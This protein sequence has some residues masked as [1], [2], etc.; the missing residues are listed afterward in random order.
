MGLEGIWLGCMSGVCLRIVSAWRM[1]AAWKDYTANLEQVPF[2]PL[3][4]FQHGRQIV[5]LRSSDNLCESESSELNW[6]LQRKIVRRTWG[7][8]FKDWSDYHCYSTTNLMQ[9]SAFDGQTLKIME[10]SRN[11]WNPGKTLLARVNIESLSVANFEGSI[12]TWC[13]LWP[14]NTWERF[15][16]E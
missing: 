15:P 13:L 6:G 7:G 4:H 2:H 5:A 14:E 9:P 3:R 11:K 12:P 16:V 10:Q 1:G 8:R